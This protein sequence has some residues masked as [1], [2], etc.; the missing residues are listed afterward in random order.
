M[1]LN[2]IAEG[3][4]ESQVKEEHKYENERSAIRWDM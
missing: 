4:Q 1:D 2:L 3:D